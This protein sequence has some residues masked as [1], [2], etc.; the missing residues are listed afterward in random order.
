[1]FASVT[2]AGEPGAS[3]LDKAYSTSTTEHSLTEAVFS[4]VYGAIAERY[5]N[6]VDVRTVALEGLSGL[7]T[8]DPSLSISQQEGAV[9]FV[10]NTGITMRYASPAPG[11]V[12][13]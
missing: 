13:G 2:L 8:I 4:A 10:T 11:D 1:M 7:T 9:T 3:A 5:L 6:P 12:R